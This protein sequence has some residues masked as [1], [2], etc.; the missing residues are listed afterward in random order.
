M[1][2]TKVENKQVIN[3]PFSNSNVTNAQTVNAEMD[4]GTVTMNRYF[5]EKSR[6]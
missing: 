4:K 1:K 6:K 5:N 3:F 2:K